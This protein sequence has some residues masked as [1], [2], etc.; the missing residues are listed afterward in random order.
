MPLTSNERDFLDGY[1]YEA[2]NGPPFGGAAT[3]LWKRIGVWYSDLSWILTAYQREI[4]AEG[5]MPAGIANLKPTSSPW[6][7]LEEVKL[8]SKVLEAELGV[9]NCDGNRVVEKQENGI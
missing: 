5:I 1:I 7:N 8:R 2:T 4:C 6:N 9:V 3:E